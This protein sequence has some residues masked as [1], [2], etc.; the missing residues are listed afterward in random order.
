MMAGYPATIASPFKHMG[1]LD[2]G[3]DPALTALLASSRD[4]P[5]MPRVLPQWALSLVL[6]TFTRAPFEPL[7]LTAP[8]FL[9]WKVFFLTLLA[10]GARKG[11]VHAIKARGV[12]HDD[13]WTSTIMFPHPGFISKTQLHTKGALS[14]KKL[15]IPASSPT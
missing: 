7:Q 15:V 4:C 14:V 3:H 13:K 6:I 5:R 2:V 8:K 1:P 10:S 12:Q 9:A 11:K